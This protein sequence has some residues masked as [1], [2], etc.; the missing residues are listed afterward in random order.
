MQPRVPFLITTIPSNVYTTEL[1]MYIL[2][3]TL[4]SVQSYGM[5]DL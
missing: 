4:N 3:I 1:P 2:S 5:K